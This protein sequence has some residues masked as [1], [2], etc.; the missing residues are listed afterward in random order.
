M[1]HNAQSDPGPVQ[2]IGRTAGNITWNYLGYGFQ[3]VL[4]L[5]L[6]W[7]FVRKISVVEYG[8]FLF[9]MS[10]SATLYLLD[11][12]ISS[13]LVQAL[14]E[15]SAAAGKERVNDILSTSF[16]ALSALGALGV[17]VFF[18][19][20]LSLPGPF[21]IPGPYL[22]E[23]F[24]VFILAGLVVQIG[25]STIA[26]EQV[27]Q[28]SHRFDRLNQVQLATGLLL[29]ALTVLVLAAGCGIVA[30]ALVQLAVAVL[31]LVIL[32]AALPVVVPGV[33]LSLI[34]FNLDSLRSLFNLG[35]WA[36]LN[37]AGSSLF[38]ACIWVALASLG[39]ME[40]AAIF[41]LANK[42]PRQLW[43]LIDKGG[44]IA[45]P[46]L[47]EFFARDD[48][49]ALR[50]VFLKTQRLLFGAMFP[51]VVLGC[52]AARPLIEVWAGPEYIAA[53]QVLQILLFGV[54]THVTGYCSTQLLYACRQTKKAAT[55]SIW[56]YV[57]SLALAGALVPRYGA[58]GLAAGIA[59]GQI[60]INC[61]WLTA[62]ACRFSR[63]SGQMLLRYIIGGL[64]IPA[65]TLG[66]AMAVVWTFSKFL[67]PQWQLAADVS[68][69]LVY[70]ATWGSRT[71]LPA[72][73]A[74]RE[75]VA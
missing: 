37:N 62:A 16:L 74:E 40:Q 44:M 8:L 30:I 19:I 7:Y 55:I 67:A 48:S 24:L 71:L 1:P 61:G 28:A 23:A 14:V 56:E 50:Q 34:R 58:V 54:A 53:A 57:V 29:A 20:A 27:Y 46:Q 73:R 15:A 31:R 60:L 45:Y 59:A 66:A 33:R 42:L 26:I 63:T 5:G 21:R 41:G 47:S 65:V 6:T 3:I 69:G 64:P 2:T 22:H 25:F 18:G 10:L 49:V 70:F 12:G 68:I 13:V 72:F 75:S 38:D 4:N 51:F 43:N 35:K 52:F 11:M 39:S 9:I 36:L 32:T 17:L